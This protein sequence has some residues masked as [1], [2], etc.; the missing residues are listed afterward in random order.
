MPALSIME[1]HVAP[2]KIKCNKKEG[3]NQ[4]ETSN[5]EMLKEASKQ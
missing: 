5:Y 3:K 2:T 4:S 1:L